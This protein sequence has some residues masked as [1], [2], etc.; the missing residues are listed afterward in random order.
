MRRVMQ[1]VEEDLAFRQEVR[2]D[3]PAP[4][5]RLRAARGQTPTDLRAYNLPTVQ[6]TL[7]D[8]AQ[9]NGTFPCALNSCRVIF[10][11]AGMFAT[12]Q[13]VLLGGPQVGHKPG[14]QSDLWMR[15]R[16]TAS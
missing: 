8:Y 13:K 10:V 5:M 14:L 15:P 7:A 4:W 12:R 9:C 1:S 3:H 11:L 16:G 6:D 2:K